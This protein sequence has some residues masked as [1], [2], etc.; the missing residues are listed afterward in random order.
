M[1]VL[2][3]NG[4]QAEEAE[5]RCCTVHDVFVLEEGKRLHFFNDVSEAF[6]QEQDMCLVERNETSYPRVLV[7]DGCLFVY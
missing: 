1:S 3:S 6:S 4:F 2:S 5:A 7:G